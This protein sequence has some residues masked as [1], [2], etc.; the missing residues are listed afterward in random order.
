[1]TSDKQLLE[2]ALEALEVAQ[3]NLRPHGDN[4]FLH[5]DG[6]Y[7]RCYCGKD[8][9]SNYLQEVV[10]KLDTAIRARLEQPEQEPVAWA[11]G[12]ENGDI[13]WSREDCFSDDPE[14]LDNPMP[15]Y[16]TPP[17]YDQG[18]KDGYKH[19]AWANTAA[20][21]QEPVA[22]IRDDGMKA[23]VSD[24]KAAWIEA[25]QS[26]LVE[27]YNVP[28]YTT[29]PSA[30]PAPDHLRDTTKMVAEPFGYFRV[31]PFGWTDCAET[32]EGAIALYERPAAQRQWVGLAPHEIGNLWAFAWT[33]DR[34]AFARAIEAKL[35]EKN[36]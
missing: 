15:L 17:T 21:V 31:E 19:G 28:A 18:W 10:E 23:I 9:L 24:E 29:P 4:C 27:D 12:D 32:D 7:N 14:W 26:D 6:E 25:G 16:T 34:V 20:P 11:E 1:M 35:K 22:W 5:D 8:S 30:Q 3:D 2:Q 33:G 13:V 36:T